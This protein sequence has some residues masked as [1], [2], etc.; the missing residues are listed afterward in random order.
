MLRILTKYSASGL[1][2]SLIH[3]F[4]AFSLIENTNLSLYKINTISF[5]TSACFGY[6]FQ[7]IITFSS[8]VTQKNFLRYF[9][10][11]LGNILI[12]NLGTSILELLTDEKKISLIIIWL[13][14][15]LINFLLHLKWTYK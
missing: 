11:I 8:A 2:A 6:F 14:I 15:I 4:M 12:I 5:I 13:L 9:S 1:I 7:T 10:V 3:V